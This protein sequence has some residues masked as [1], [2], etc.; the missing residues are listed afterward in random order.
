MPYTKQ[1][2]VDGA[3]GGT[4]VSAARLNA[5]ETGIDTA[6]DT[7]DA[8]ETPAGA[9]AKV[10]THANDTTAAHAASAVALTPTGGVAATNVQT[11]IQELDAEK[12]TPA[13]AQAKVDAHVAATDPHGDRAY[14]NTAIASTV[15]Q[16]AKVANT[17][18]QSIPTATATYV[19]FD[20]EQSDTDGMVNL[21]TANDRITVQTAGLYLVV[22]LVD[23]Q[24]NN[25]GLRFCNIFRVGTPIATDRRAASNESEA[26]LSALVPAVVGEYFR[27]QV[28]QDSGVALNLNA[29]V[30]T[31]AAIRL[32]A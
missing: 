25:T 13:G 16:H 28:Y 26:S 7:A 9:Q 8:A 22:A 1:T 15:R 12:E 24:A 21:G 19:T 5:I 31:L 27:L 23:W 10:D 4:P 6:H 18:A 2:W 14:T 11:A 17:V 32:S 3:A 30:V 29:N 20:T